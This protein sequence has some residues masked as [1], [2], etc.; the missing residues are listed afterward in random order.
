MKKQT[1][2]T[3]EPK[4][5]LANYPMS[6]VCVEDVFLKACAECVK[7]TIHGHEHYLH[8]TTAFALY[9]QLQ[10]YFQGLSPVEKAMMLQFGSE[11]GPELLASETGYNCPPV[12][13]KQDNDTACK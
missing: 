4:I 8:R 11:L 2:I 5:P 7:V 6:H 13:K 10:K 9:E 1:N 3:H 12:T